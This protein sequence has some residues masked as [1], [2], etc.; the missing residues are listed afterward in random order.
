[1]NFIEQPP[2]YLIQLKGHLDQRWLSRFE[3][4]VITLKPD[5]ETLI[6]GGMDQSTLHSLLNI[7]RDLGLEIISLHIEQDKKEK[8]KE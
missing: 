6:R 4:L 1:M 3:G 7:I 8:G 5:G 2:I